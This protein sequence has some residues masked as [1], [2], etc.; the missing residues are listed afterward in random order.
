MDIQPPY[1]G[2]P[3]CL[4][5]NLFEVTTPICL[6]VDPSFEVT[7]ND[8][9]LSSD[10]RSRLPHVTK[11]TIQVFIG[12]LVTILYRQTHVDITSCLLLPDGV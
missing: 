11:E 4:T 5:P 9:E 6:P 3:C 10:Y 1:E 2:I 7:G 12:Q 8:L